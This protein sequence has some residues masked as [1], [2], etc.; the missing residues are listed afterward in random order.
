M[1]HVQIA[2]E[3]TDF[4]NYLF[5]LYENKGEKDKPKEKD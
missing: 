3:K 4:I 1:T 5:S 2:K